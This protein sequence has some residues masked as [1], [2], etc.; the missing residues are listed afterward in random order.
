MCAIAH[1]AE[2]A[3]GDAHGLL[4]IF[5]SGVLEGAV[6]HAL[7]VVLHDEQNDKVVV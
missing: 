6:H 5:E 4:L 3:D 7:H 1:V 2:C